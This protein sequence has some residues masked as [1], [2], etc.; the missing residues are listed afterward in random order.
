MVFG[1]GPEAAGNPVPGTGARS[2][3]FA[4]LRTWHRSGH[5]AAGRGGRIVGGGC[6]LISPGNGPAA[7]LP[8]HHGPT[9]SA[10]WTRGTRPPGSRTTTSGVADSSSTLTEA[11]ISDALQGRE[12]AAPDGVVVVT[13]SLYLLGDL[14]P[15]LVREA[16]GPPATLARAR[17]G[18]D[19]TEAVAIEDSNTGVRSAEAAGC[20]VLAVPNHVPVLEGPGRVLRDTL[21]GLAAADLLGLFEAGGRSGWPGGRS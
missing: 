11:A 21:E 19:P 1:S 10:G 16:A 8:V 13:G 6:G 7:R 15:G 18:I 20:L 17:K 5:H 12:A 14:R 2:G 4:W 3:A 9:A